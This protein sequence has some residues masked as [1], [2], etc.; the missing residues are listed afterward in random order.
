MKRREFLA[1]TGAA[2]CALALRRWPGEA[3]AAA[4]EVS[5]R[6]L[7]RWRGFNLLE[8]FSLDCNQ[9]FITGNHPYRRED[10]EWI[11]ELGFD[12]VRLPMD[13]RCWTDAS[14]LYRLKEECLKEIDQ[15]V[16][17]GRKY[18][19]HVNLCF[20]R[21]PGYCVNPPKEARDLWTDEEIL[22]VC[23]HHWGQFARRYRGIPSSAL[24]FNLL[25]EP[26]AMPAEPYVRVVRRL[27][28][29]IRDQ[30]PGRLILADGLRWG[31]DPLPA[32]ADLGIAQATRGYD[33]MPVSHHH[34]FW[35]GQSETAPPPEWP[36]R[37]GNTLWDREALR[38]SCIAPWKAVEALGVG[39]HVSEWG[40]Y[41]SPHAVVLAW[42]RDFLELWKEAGWGWAL[43]NFRGRFGVL[44]SERPDVRYEA[45]RGHQLDRQMLDLLQAY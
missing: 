15:A 26:A 23:A 20:H 14:D 35:A 21:A 7:P 43:W 42:M 27:T 34:A 17:W 5:P 25:N 37:Q 12:F 1:G 31:R 36:L 32:L 40:S 3:P 39:V 44:D 16:A 22:K 9:P 11:H 38:R 8:K 28:E 33:P 19:V 4:A 24:S 10:F 2:G 6:R 41:R 18:R 29:A 30:D 45:W 13:Y